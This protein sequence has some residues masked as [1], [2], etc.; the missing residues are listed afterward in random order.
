MSTITAEER[1]AIRE[2]FARLL[3]EKASE[4][5]LRRTMSSEDGYD[6]DLWQALA[7]MGLPALLIPAEHGGIGAGAVEV[8]ALMEEAGAA[9]MAGPFLTSAVLATGLLGA[10]GAESQARLLPRLASGEC[11]ATVAITG[12]AGTWTPDGITVRAD[13][14]GN[15]STL[16]G[17][18]SFVPFARSA[19]I[20]LVLAST[21]SG[22]GCYEVA[23]DTPGVSIEPLKTWDPT[24]R[25]SKITFAGAEA[26]LIEGI[27]G[28][29]IEMMLDLARVALAGE[30]AGAARRIFEITVEY[31]KTR[32]QF[33]RPIGGFQALKHWAA[34]LLIDVES[35]TSAARAAAQAVAEDA[36]D[37]RVLVSLAAFACADAFSTVAAAAVQMHGGI[38]FT[39]EHPAHLYLRR[40]RADAQLFGTSDTYR[41]RY[42]TALEQAA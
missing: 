41:E 15:H 18:S 27:D 37:K 24:L 6:S 30:Q 3:V 16:S 21:D 19:D 25:F 36:S 17:V 39:W 32:V 10:A 8:E 1:A 35:A 4:A 12:E 42:L 22:L 33:G 29:A 20:I 28:D 9:L 5:D 2:G 14:L 26:H 34:D 38:A 40:A 11:I 7:G 23:P 31:L 13:L